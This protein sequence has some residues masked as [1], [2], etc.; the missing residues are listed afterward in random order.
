M[1]K[2]RNLRDYWDFSRKYNQYSRASDLSHGLVDEDVELSEGAQEALRTLDLKRAAYQETVGNLNLQFLGCDS[3][4]G[5][6]CDRPPSHYFTSIDYWLAKYGGRNP[7]AFD[8]PNPF[9]LRYYLLSPL[10][11]V[12]DKLSTERQDKAEAR[13]AASCVLLGESGCTLPHAERPIK[14]ILYACEPMREAMDADT[15]ATYTAAI[16]GLHEISLETF[17]ILKEE[18]GYPASYGRR[19]LTVLP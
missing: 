6:C 13:S 7:Q 8:A 5:S 9:Y 10:R 3:C 18:G 12:A 16:R 14:C 2:Q 11:Y 17:R 15:R 4:K 19:R 1:S